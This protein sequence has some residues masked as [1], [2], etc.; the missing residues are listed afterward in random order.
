MRPMRWLGACAALLVVAAP[1]VAHAQ[2]ARR[3]PSCPDGALEGK[4]APTIGEVLRLRGEWLSRQNPFA[5]YDLRPDGRWLAVQL[6]RPPADAR[7][8]ATWAFRWLNS[9]V[10]VYDVES[11]RRVA[12]LDGARDGESWATPRWS[13]SGG[14]LA[15]MHVGTST[16]DRELYVWDVGRRAPA[17]VAPGALAASLRFGQSVPDGLAGPYIWVDSVT[18]L[19]ATLPSGS[20]TLDADDPMTSL[21]REWAA[22]GAG[23]RPSASVIDAHLPASI[24]P[25]H[26]T[27]GVPLTLWRI[28]ARTGARRALLTTPSVRGRTPRD[29]LLSPD[30]AMLAFTPDVRAIDAS[31]GPVPV[32]NRA[33]TELFLVDVGDGRVMHPLPGRHVTLVRWSDDGSSV[34]VRIVAPAGDTIV[35]VRRDGTVDRSGARVLATGTRTPRDSAPPRTPRAEDEPAR[36]L[37]RVDGRGEHLIVRHGTDERTIVSVDEDVAHLAVCRAWYVRYATATGVVVYARVTMPPG[38]D[39]GRRYPVLV[40]M[41]PGT[42]HTESDARRDTLDY[43]AASASWEPALFA[44]HGYV[45]VEPS[46]PLHGGGADREGEFA[47]DILPALDSLIAYGVADPER[48]ALDG[49]SFGGL[50]TVAV[51]EQTHRFRA[52]SARHGL[53]DLV[54]MY[55]Q[56]NPVRRLADDAGEHLWAPGWAEGGQGHLGVPP[57]GN[58]ETYHR[59]SPLY[60]VG[61]I[62]TPVLLVAGEMDYAAPITQGEELFTALNRL[63]KPVRFIRYAG[64]GHGNASAVNIRHLF[65]QMIEWFDDWLRPE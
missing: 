22:A 41:Y 52:A 20:G 55:G 32:L 63:G 28:D 21:P 6:K 30:R 51:L 11:A 62:T 18:M 3:P 34:G 54:S 42:V 26:A 58:W 4:H 19:A 14:R 8:H 53:Y 13:P 61:S 15:V 1:D 24:T 59:A 50:G 12:V 27:P 16:L 60:R 5:S 65:E 47:G 23:R 57:Y 40:Q 31:A 29:I 43:V 25:A 7:A 35:Q 17:R 46:V 64:E 37:T 36:I 56:F 39:A 49:V 38:Y 10:A 48:L 9:D 45:V 44:A 2:S 33:E